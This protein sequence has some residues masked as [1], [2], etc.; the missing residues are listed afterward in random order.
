MFLVQQISILEL[1]LKNHDVT[2]EVT[3]HFK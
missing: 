2:L 3:L 1:I